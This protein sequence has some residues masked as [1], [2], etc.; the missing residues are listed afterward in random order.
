M[1]LE[2]K[3][4]NLERSVNDLRVGVATMDATLSLLAK[5][6]D[7][8]KLKIEF[9]TTLPTLAKQE[10]LKELKAKFDT[11]LP[12]LVTKTWLFTGLTLMVAAQIFIPYLRTILHLA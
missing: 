5:E 3:V 10:D 11:V 12:H 9:E 8:N 4:Y 2:D 1:E 7:L 6:S